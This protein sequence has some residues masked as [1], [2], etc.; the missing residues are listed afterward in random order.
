MSTREDGE[1][2]LLIRENRNCKE[3]TVKEPSMFREKHTWRAG[4]PGGSVQEERLTRLFEPSWV[5]NIRQGGFGVD[6]LGKGL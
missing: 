2:S 5:L 3:S 4:Y 6:P 1:C